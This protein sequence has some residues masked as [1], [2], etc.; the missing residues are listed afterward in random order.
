MFLNH[1]LFRLDVVISLG[2][3]LHFA[4]NADL[5][6]E[7]TVKLH[8]GR[9]KVPVFA[10]FYFLDDVDAIVAAIAVPAF[11]HRGVAFCR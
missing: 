1:E 8:N 10:D 2:M 9:V 3:G 4:M 5:V 7:F 11:G 6:A